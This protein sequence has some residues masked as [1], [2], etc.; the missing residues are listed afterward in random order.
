MHPSP[1]A[2]AGDRPAPAPYT[3]A[4]QRIIAAALDLFAERGVSG[5]SLQMIAD[6]VGVTK[7]AVYH[8]FHA[9]E[10]IVV[11]AVDVELAQ[12]FAALDDAERGEPGR[13]A[14]EIVLAQV[15]DNAV[16]RRRMVSTL[17]HDPVINRLLANQEHFQQFMRRLYR[18]LVGDSRS[19]E[20][21][22][23]AAMIAAAIGGAVMHPFVADLDDATL[24]AELLRVTRQFLDVTE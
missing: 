22:V 19:P 4:Q 24:R 3:A 20:A 10:E 2:P 13:R 7:A 6:A 16:A 11:A 8:Q 18:V 21:R 1:A 5:T 12:V 17:Q 15:I 14:A 9:K 23:R